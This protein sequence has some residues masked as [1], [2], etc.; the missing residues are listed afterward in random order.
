MHP[1]VR[2]ASLFVALFLSGTAA[3][4]Y[5]S[6]WGRMLQRVFGV[7]DLAIATVLATFFLGLGLGSALGARYA[8]RFAGRVGLRL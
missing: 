6:T 3:L 1:T 5:Q 7:S 4:V 2:F 8:T